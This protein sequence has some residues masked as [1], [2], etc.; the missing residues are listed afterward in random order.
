MQF[1]LPYIFL[2]NLLQITRRIKTPGIYFSCI[3]INMHRHLLIYSNDTTERSGESQ[4]ATCRALG[5]NIKKTSCSLVYVN[6]YH[7]CIVLIHWELVNSFA[8]AIWARYI[9]RS[10]AMINAQKYIAVHG[11]Y[12]LLIG[13]YF[14]LEKNINYVTKN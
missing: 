5:G 6:S 9:F 10:G 12:D 14:S 7:S 1:S 3:V 2:H 8:A 13:K 4:R 11:Q